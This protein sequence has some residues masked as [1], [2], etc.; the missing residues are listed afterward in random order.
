MADLYMNRILLCGE[1]DKI[2]ALLEAVRYDTM[3]RG[4]IDFCKVIPFPRDEEITQDWRGQY[5]GLDRNSIPWEWTEE[6]AILFQTAWGNA[7]GIVQALAGRFQDVEMEYQWASERIGE[8]AG[9]MQFIEG[10][11][12]AEV[13]RDAG[14][15]AAIEQAAWLWGVDEQEEMEYD[16]DIRT[17]L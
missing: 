5:W 10:C 6:N 15:L 12:V 11:C 4:T 14:S 1:Q 9:L 7:A 8:S 3:Q 16:T 13:F 2:D 17:Q